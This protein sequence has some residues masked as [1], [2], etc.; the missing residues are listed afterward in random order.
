MSDSF[1]VLSASL[2]VCEYCTVGKLQ[3]CWNLSTENWSLSV[4]LNVFVLLVR[5]LWFDVQV[6]I[7]QVR[8]LVYAQLLSGSCS[9]WMSDSCSSWAAANMLWPCWSRHLGLRVCIAF[10]PHES[11]HV[12]LLWRQ[13]NCS[14]G[15]YFCFLLIVRL[16]QQYLSFVSWADSNCKAVASLFSATIVSSV[17]TFSVVTLDCW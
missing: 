17:I 5:H 10:L 11:G 3:Y 9:S 1:F 12:N 8:Q 7:I 13:Y 4:L 2:V 16:I 6:L 15:W 14:V